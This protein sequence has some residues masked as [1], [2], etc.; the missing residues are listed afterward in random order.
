MV[1]ELTSTR[2]SAPARGAHRASDG[3]MRCPT[4]TQL[5]AQPPSK[6][7]WLWTEETP[8]LP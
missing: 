4:F 6:K 1:S 7:G 3:S 8:Q 2:N 5:P